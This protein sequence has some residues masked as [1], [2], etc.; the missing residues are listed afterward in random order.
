[1]YASDIS[2]LMNFRLVCNFV[3]IGVILKI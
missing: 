3:K 1:L 2:A